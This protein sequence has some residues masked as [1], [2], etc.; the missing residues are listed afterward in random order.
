VELNLRPEKNVQTLNACLERGYIHVRFTDTKGATELGVKIDE[1]TAQAALAAVK[2][3][4]G[5]IK[6]A[7]NLWLDYVHVRCIAD[8]DLDT[9]EGIGY[10][11]LLQ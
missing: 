9:Y 7:R 10:I 8:I 1:S 11:E 3:S 5:T 2:D 4:A 6:V